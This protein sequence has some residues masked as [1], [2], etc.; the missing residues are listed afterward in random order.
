MKLL[1][2][3]LV[4]LL[5]VSLASA[6]GNHEPHELNAQKISIA[7]I[8]SVFYELEKQKIESSFVSLNLEVDDEDLSLQF[9]VKD[10]KVGFDWLLLAKR[11]VADR[12]KFV[13]YAES[14][15]FTVSKKRA[16]GIAYLRVEVDD[17]NRLERVSN[18]AESSKN[19]DKEHS[20]LSLCQNILVDIYGL[21]LTDEVSLFAKKVILDEVQL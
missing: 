14:K 6:H 7:K 12:E 8:D 2:I 17:P 18:Q 9:S 15:G 5:G 16:N 4:W 11:N 1:L 10:D 21:S 13:S 3:T 20:L 19:A